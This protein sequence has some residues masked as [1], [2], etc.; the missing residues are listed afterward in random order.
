M[1]TG[2][3]DPAHVF[4]AFSQGMDGVF[5]GGCRLEECNYITHGNYHALNMVL[6][7]KR[8]MSHI[9]LN[10]ERLRQEFMSGSEGTL[11]VEVVNDF[12]KQVKEMGPLGQGEELEENRLKLRLRAIAR[13]IPYIRLVLNERLRLQFDTLEDYKRFYSG[14]EFE[15]LFKELIADKLAISQIMLLLREQSLSTGEICELLSLTPSEASR[16]LNY[17]ARQGLVNYAENRWCASLA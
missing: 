5:I 6:L 11:F 14:E 2:R 15:R 7:L 16:H 10:P 13:L 1:C 4:R 8:I 3:V 9:G 17:S 12:V